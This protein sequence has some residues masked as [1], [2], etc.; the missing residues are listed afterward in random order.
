MNG[1]LRWI[2][3]GI[4]VG[5]L[6]AGA[7]PKRDYPVQPVSFNAV[8]IADR[9]WSPR[10][11]TNRTVTIPFALEKCEETGRIDNFS[12]AGGQLGG[13]FQ[14]DFPFDDTDPYK[15]IEGASYSLSVFPDPPLENYL[16]EIIAKIAS[17]QEDDGYLYTARTI[18]SEKPVRWVSDKRW[19]NLRSSHELYN[20]GHLFEAAAAH[21]LATGKRSLLDVALKNADLLDRVFGPDKIRDIPGHQVVEIGLTKL[22]RVTGDEK[23]LNLSKFFLDERGQAHERELYGPYCQD[24]KPVV[25][26]DEAV[27]HAVRASY[28]YAGMAD[29]AALTGDSGYVTAIDRIW[30]N[31]ASKKLYIT[32]GIGARHAGEAFGDNYE[33]PNFSAYNETCAAIGNAIWNHRMF[34]LHGDAKYIDVLERVL[35]NGMLSGIS[36]NGDRFFY[37]NPLAA[38]PGGG[39]RSH[40]FGCSC[41]PSNV[42]RFMPSIPGY[43][44]AR[45]GDILYVNLFASGHAETEIESNTVRIE[46]ETRYPWNGKVKITV[47][48]ER[49]GEFAVYVRIPGWARNQPVPSDLYRYMNESRKKPVLKVNGRKISLDMEKGYA[50]IRRAWKRGD[51]IE[52][53]LPMPVRRVLAHDKIEADAGRVALERGP[54]VYCAESLDNGGHISDIVL[55]DNVRLRSQ[56]RKD[57]LNGITII[58]GNA[59]ILSYGRD[60]KT[61]KKKRTKFTAI[62]YYAWAHRGKGEMAVWLARESSAAQPLKPAT[63]ASKSEISVSFMREGGESLLSVHG[64]N[65]RVEPENSDDQT[66]LRFHWWPHLGTREWVQYDFEKYET[67]DSASVYWFDDTGHGA[68]RIPKSWRLLYNDGGQWKPVSNAGQ[69]GVSKDQFNRVSFDPVTAAGLR[70]EI[71]LQENLSG[72]ILEWAVE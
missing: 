47:E 61:L 68:C 50:R 11:E 48:P 18:K 31:V 55:P 60:G 5:V 28:M 37:P 26:Q 71:Q 36:L 43:V 66:I 51:W 72:G 23:Y 6:N 24:H 46:Q 64:M 44:Y 4:L 40:W 39:T 2:A 13:A 35:Y 34:L 10:L 20:S 33:L 67:I 25:E 3:A 62:P 32:G 8:H 30:E 9:F 53:N 59:T 1:S 14:G 42:T 52:L 57:L 69:F 58:N 22:Y 49:P 29:T 38:G 63:I 16:D 70:I 7:T 19:A 21:F 65:D 15:I 12:R 27:G 54:I 17:A 56:F 45:Q 41:C